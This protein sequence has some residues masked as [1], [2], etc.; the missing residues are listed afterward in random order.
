MVPLSLADL[1]MEGARMT[2]AQITKI[3]QLFIK[4]DTL[5]TPPINCVYLNQLGLDL[6]DMI[7]PILGYDSVE[8]VDETV[9][10]IMLM[11]APGR[12]PVC[13]DYATYISDKMHDHLMNLSRDRVFKYTS[14]IY[15]LLLYFQ[16]EKFSFPMKREDAQGN[17]KSV[18]YWTSVFHLPCYSPYTYCEFIDHFIHPAMT[19]LLGSPP[20]RLTDEMQRLLHLSKAYSIG[21]WYFYQ[22]HTVIRIYGCELPPFRLP[23]FVPMRLFSLEYF[24]QFGFVDMFHFSGRGK[25]A[26][27]KVK[28]QL[29]HFLY[30]ERDEGWKEADTILGGLG[31]K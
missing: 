10:H 11:F 19:L 30:N 8:Y 7:S 27:L 6:V 23:R 2:E 18:V 16:H 26:Q 28:S 1:I 22:H 17:L 25:K 4:A 12:K 13:Y 24:R 29:G 14:Y 5:Q 31:L 3:N 9:M 20:P 21:D 15:H